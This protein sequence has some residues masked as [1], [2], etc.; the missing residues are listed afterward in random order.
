MSDTWGMPGAASF[1]GKP[2]G[3]QLA[4]EAEQDRRRALTGTPEDMAAERARQLKVLT[5]R[6]DAML[7]AADHPILSALLQAHGPRGEGL[8]PSCF[9]CPAVNNQCGDSDPESWPCGV[10]TFISD[11]METP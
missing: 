9:E 6:H 11:R 2:T 4:A 8:F 7:A 10:W 1:M 5:D 3:A